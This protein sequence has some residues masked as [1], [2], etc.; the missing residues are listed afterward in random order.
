MEDHVD[1]RVSRI[2]AHVSFF[3]F[4]TFRSFEMLNV[5]EDPCREVVQA[6]DFRSYF[7]KNVAD[8]AAEKPGPAG[9]QDTLPVKRFRVQ[10][11]LDLF[12][13]FLDDRGSQSWH[14]DHSDPFSSSN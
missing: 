12:Y 3:E 7:A 13:A 8:P 14:L 1:F 4:E 6:D 11:F 10:G 2:C 5:L 9:Y